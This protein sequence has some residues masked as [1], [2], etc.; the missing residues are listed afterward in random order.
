MSEPSS[1]QALP[2]SVNWTDPS[3]EAAFNRWLEQ[4]A[5]PHVLLP[6][7]LRPASADASFRRYLRVDAFDGSRI[8]MDAPPDKED[9]RP[10]VRVAA[11]MAEAGLHVP[12]V[13]AWDEAQGFLLLDDLGTRTMM[14]VVDPD[15]APANQDLYLRAVDAL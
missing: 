8:I 9:C 11:L 12:R 6:S 2:A 15:N 14:D 13:L 7:T 3:R 10:F 1:P 4:V 5:V